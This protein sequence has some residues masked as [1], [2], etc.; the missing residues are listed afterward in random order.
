MWVEGKDDI[1][2]TSKSD[3]KPDAKEE[4]CV[5]VGMSEVPRYYRTVKGRSKGFL[6]SALLMIRKRRSRRDGCALRVADVADG[7]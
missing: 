6:G 4:G 1:E 3:R 5:M 2:G 7:V